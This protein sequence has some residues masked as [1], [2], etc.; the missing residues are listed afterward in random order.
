MWVTGKVVALNEV[1]DDCFAQKIMGDGMAIEIENENI[2][3]PVNGEV[4]MTFPTKHAI[5]IKTSNGSEILIHLGI[6]TVELN[7]EGFENFVNI[8][9]KVKTGDLI[10]K[11]DINYIKKNNKSL[12]SPI[13][14]TS[15]ENIKILAK[16]SNVKINEDIF[17]V[18]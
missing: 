10:A 4:I 16:N 13:I 18:V 17:E 5:G 1:P 3:A 8:G 11:V 15:K 7:G 14:V 9:D 2:V 12:I 6:N